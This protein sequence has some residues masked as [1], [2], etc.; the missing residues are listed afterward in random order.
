MDRHDP[1]HIERLHSAPEY[2]ESLR[3]LKSSFDELA[4]GGMYP[5]IDEDGDFQIASDPPMTQETMDRTREYAP[6]I[7][8]LLKMKEEDIRHQ[9]LID[10]TKLYQRGELDAPE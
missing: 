4:K 2:W 5:T 9:S 10:A 7:A 6:L 8:P 1:E 3:N